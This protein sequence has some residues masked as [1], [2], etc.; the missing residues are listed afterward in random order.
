MS[1]PI[2]TA[3]IQRSRRLGVMAA[4]SRS[5]LREQ[6]SLTD[7]DRDAVFAAALSLLEV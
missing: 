6:A 3:G 4:R 1:R 7:E 5:W 2:W